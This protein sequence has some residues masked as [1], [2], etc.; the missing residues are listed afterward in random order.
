MTRGANDPPTFP[1]KFCNDTSEE[2]IWGGATSIGIEFTAAV[3]KLN[4][5]HIVIGQRV[6]GHDPVGTD[7]SGSSRHDAAT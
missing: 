1:P 6:E 4:Q 7:G 2:T 5:A 3:E